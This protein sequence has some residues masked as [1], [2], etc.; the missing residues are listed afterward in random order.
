MDSGCRTAGLAARASL[1]LIYGQ[2]TA[3]T[4][5]SA[6]K[7]STS[8]RKIDMIEIERFDLKMAKGLASEDVIELNRRFTTREKDAVHA[9]ICIRSKS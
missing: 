5:G 2:E 3:V 1:S 9:S 8:R 4:R 7:A 6:W